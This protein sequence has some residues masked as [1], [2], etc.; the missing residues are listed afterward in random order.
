MTEFCY[1]EF[2]VGKDFIN[3]KV[4]DKVVCCDEY[5]HDYI[6]H[7][8]RVTCM[9]IDEENITENNPAGVVFYGD[10]IDKDEWGDD[11]LT[12]VTESNFVRFC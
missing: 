7:K 5:A 10:D 11:Y 1:K 8:L 4:G 9:E 3:I 12:R 6:E 2:D